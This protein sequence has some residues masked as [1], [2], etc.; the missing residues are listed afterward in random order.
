MSPPSTWRSKEIFCLRFVDF[1]ALTTVNYG[2]HKIQP[3]INTVRIFGQ[4]LF[5]RININTAALKVL[6]K[7][8]LFPWPEEVLFYVVGVIV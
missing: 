6:R 3:N 8:P 7:M 4:E 5:V 1:Y 2:S